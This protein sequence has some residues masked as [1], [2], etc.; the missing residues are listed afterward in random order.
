MDL[1]PY[2]VTLIA[3]LFLGLEYGILLGIA[4][5]L[6]FVLH[7]S[8]RPIITIDNEKTPH[9][10][11]FIVTPSS[12]LEFPSAEFL[13]EKV[14]QNCDYPKTTVLLNGK[15]ISGID[16]TVAK[17]CFKFVHILSADF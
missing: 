7:S 15:Y 1:I 2:A 16:A 5:N 4:S 6:I 14:I 11:V 3:S 10:D 9:G 13:R 17:V 8:A 12:N